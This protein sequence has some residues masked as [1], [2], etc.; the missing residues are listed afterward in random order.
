ML[1]NL[2]REHTRNSFVEE[3]FKW[4]RGDDLKRKGL[5]CKLVCH[6]CHRRVMRGRFD[7]AV[8]FG[9]T[10]SS[11]IIIGAVNSRSTPEQ[12]HQGEKKRGSTFD[13]D[14]QE[15]SRE[16]NDEGP[17]RRQWI[18]RYPS[19]IVSVLGT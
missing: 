9:C 15:E 16:G 7:A 19:S 5:A 1:T 10:L 18:F 3:Q 8:I 2:I 13:H 6:D 12:Q 4:A 11:A 14:M 17:K